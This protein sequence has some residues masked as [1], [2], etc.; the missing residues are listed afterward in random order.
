LGRLRQDDVSFPLAEFSRV[1]VRRLASVGSSSPSVDVEHLGLD[2]ED[3]G[4]ALDFG[5]AAAGEG[6]AG[7]APVTRCRRWSR[8]NEL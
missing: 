5:G 1:M 4:G 3:L 8:D 7:H 6:A 2:A